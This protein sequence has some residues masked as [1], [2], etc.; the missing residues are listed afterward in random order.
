MNLKSFFSNNYQMFIKLGIIAGILI[1]G[2]MIFSNEVDIL[3]PSTSASVID[4]LKT[5]V[6]NFSS[7]ASYSIE[8]R[9]D[10]SIDKIMNKTDDIISNEISQTGNFISNEISEVKESSQKVINKKIPNVN[11]IES[12]KNIFVT[13]LTS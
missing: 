10:G 3:F 8:E 2:G 5:D 7:K 12:I 1:L 6:S 11:P 4:S 13:N 9:I